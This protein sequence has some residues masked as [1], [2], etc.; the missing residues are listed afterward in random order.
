MTKLEQFQALIADLGETTVDQ[1]KD[2]LDAHN[3]WDEDFYTA[4]LDRAKRSDIRQALRRLKGPDGRP[5]WYSVVG[6]AEEEDAGKRLYKQEA[7]FNVE[8]YR[9]VIGAAI[10]RAQYWQGQAAHL[11]DNLHKRYGE[12]LALPWE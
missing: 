7:L 3:H 11:R 12:Q 9:Q 2:R 4:V 8:D 10:A 5:L 1:I 6:N